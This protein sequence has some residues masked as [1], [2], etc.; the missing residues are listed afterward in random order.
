MVVTVTRD[1]DDDRRR[2]VSPENYGL[3]VDVVELVD[4]VYVVSALLG[5]RHGF[6]AL[7]AD[8]VVRL[9]LVERECVRGVVWAGELLFP[10]DSSGN[11]E[12][13]GYNRLNF[14]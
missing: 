1:E 12:A 7:P 8:E 13:A 5:H 6:P 14:R 10:V 2:V 11:R 9:A 3:H 4:Q